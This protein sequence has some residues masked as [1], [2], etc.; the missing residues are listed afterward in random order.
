MFTS[1]SQA[2]ELPRTTTFCNKSTVV[3]PYS[4]PTIVLGL[5]RFQRKSNCTTLSRNEKT[6]SRASEAWEQIDHDE[7]S[8]MLSLYY[9]VWVLIF[10]QKETFILLS[11]TG[12][13]HQ[14]YVICTNPSVINK[15]ITI[16]NVISVL[17]WILILRT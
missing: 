6:S 13:V 11:L 16:I 2:G 5:Q 7:Y 17:F 4:N 14:V 9:T 10:M 8:I 1:Y 12:N 15:Y 3:T